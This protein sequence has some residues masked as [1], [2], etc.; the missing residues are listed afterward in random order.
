MLG[1]PFMPFQQYMADVL[2]EYDPDTK[3]L[4]YREG[5]IALPRQE[6]KTTFTL[7]KTTHRGTRMGPRQRI[8]YTAQTRMKALEKFRD[9]LVPII[10][11]SIYNRRGSYRVRQSNGSEAILWEN[12]SIFGIDAP[13]ETAG[14]GDSLDEGVIDE[15]WALRD[16]SVEEAFAPAMIARRNAQLLVLSTAGNERSVYWYRKIVNGREMDGLPSSVAFF[17]WS[18][19]V[20]EDPEDPRTWRKCMPALGYTITEATIRAELERAKRNPEGME[21]FRRA[22]LNQWV[23]IP[24]LDIVLPKLI[25]LEDFDDCIDRRSKMVGRRVLVP[26]VSQDRTT[27]AIVAVSKSSRVGTHV[28]VVDHRPGEGTEWLMGRLEQLFASRRNTIV[29]AHLGGQ[30]GSFELDMK[31]KFKDRF[32]PVTDA[33]LS[34]GCGGV[35]TGIREGTLKHLGSQALRDAV[36]GATRSNRGVNGSWRFVRTSEASDITP[37]E[38]AAVGWYANDLPDET[39]PPAATAPAEKAKREERELWRPSQRLDI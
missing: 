4:I 35:Y 20:D 8:R 7:A 32:H 10:D 34:R 25:V 16:D 22:Y 28:E 21:L 29:A 31:R 9:E 14:H 38:G 19:D 2:G 15:A 11:G 39:P 6:G 12:G 24:Q 33:Q 36:E 30:V 17:E 1:K 26:M 13:T 18:A 27:A 3:T 37:L 5:D 23:R